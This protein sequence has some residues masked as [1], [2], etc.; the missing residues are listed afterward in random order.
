MTVT[1]DPLATWPR[2][3]N[4]TLMARTVLRGMRRSAGWMWCR[5]L[6]CGFFVERVTRI[7]LALSAWET[8]RL[9]LNRR[10]TSRSEWTGVA[11]ADP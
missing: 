3:A 5:P 1:A 7:E 4:G 10:L 9:R 11:V 2:S 8:E 6:A